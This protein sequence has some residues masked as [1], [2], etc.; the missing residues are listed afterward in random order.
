MKKAIK[1]ELFTISKED[2]KIKTKKLNDA[3]IIDQML[4]VNTLLDSFELHD[5]FY[6]DYTFNYSYSF[7]YNLK[8][9]TNKGKIK[10]LNIRIIYP[11]LETQDNKDIACYSHLCA[12]DKF[13]NSFHFKRLWILQPINLMWLTNMIIILFATIIA[14][15][16]N[17]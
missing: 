8:V 2:G 6:Q 15:L 10:R 5:E 1:I 3:K 9:I 17:C 11:A 16:K 14:F 4:H 13:I 12:S 7:P